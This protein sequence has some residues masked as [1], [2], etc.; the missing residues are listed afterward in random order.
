MFAQG[1][2]GGGVPEDT[3]GDAGAEDAEAFEEGEVGDG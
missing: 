2:D 3:E 1:D